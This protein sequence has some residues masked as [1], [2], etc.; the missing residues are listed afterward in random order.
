V[1]NFLLESCQGNGENHLMVSAIVLAA[2]E[3]RRMGDFK[4]LLPFK[5]KTFV[6]CCVDNLLAAGVEEIFVITGHREQEV[7]HALARRNVRFVFNANY[8]A[9]MS[10]SIISG[11]TALD[12]KTTAILIALADQPQI[13]TG[14]IKKVIAVFET[15]QPLLVVPTFEDR[16]GHPIVLNAKLKQEILALDPNEGL[17]QI[18][19]THK[20]ETIYVEVA[21]KA[22]LV[23]FDYRQ[24]YENFLREN[25]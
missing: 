6:E 12:E 22:V 17:R 8:K 5:G 10:S 14:I 11:V 19:H 24:D 9:G 7:R 18:V 3:S 16:R 23:D 4:Q 25:D 21:D 13:D 1:I 20:D 15:T 2:G